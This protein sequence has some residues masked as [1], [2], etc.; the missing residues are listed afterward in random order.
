[1][2]VAAVVLVTV[3]GGGNGCG[4]GNGSEIGGVIRVQCVHVGI[5]G[6]GKMND[7]RIFE[8][9]MGRITY[10]YMPGPE[11]SGKTKKNG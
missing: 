8:L 4:R 3:V 7:S 5:I 10:T 9:R 6:G 2:V 11:S 1:M